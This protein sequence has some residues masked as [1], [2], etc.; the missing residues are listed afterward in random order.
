MT[1][2]SSQHFTVEVTV[3]SGFDLL[4]SCRQFT[5]QQVLPAKQPGLY[6]KD[7]HH[8]LYHIKGPV[9]LKISTNVN[10]VKRCLIGKFHDCT[11]EVVV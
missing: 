1:V 10:L 11:R 8:R 3:T 9:Q 7:C 6:P 2:D 4:H 5:W